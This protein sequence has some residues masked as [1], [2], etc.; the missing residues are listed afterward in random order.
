M[1]KPEGIEFGRP[2]PAGIGAGCLWA[3]AGGV[4]VVF[5]A[6]SLWVALNQPAAQLLGAVLWS[7]V[8]LTGIAFIVGGWFTAHGP[9]DSRLVL[10]DTAIH[11]PNSPSF[12]GYWTLPLGSIR[13]V[14]IIRNDVFIE[15]LG[16]LHLLVAVELDCFTSEDDASRFVG[17][18]NRR[19]G[20]GG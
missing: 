19:I 7:L 17:E 4:A 16:P 14:K 8:V 2:A 13:R 1:P 11:I 12:L 9:R 3:L 15:R 5:G 6:V 18:L 20:K 10:T